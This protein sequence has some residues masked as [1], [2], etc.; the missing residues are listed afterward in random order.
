MQSNVQFNTKKTCPVPC[1][2]RW[3]GV[4]DCASWILKNRILINNLLKENLSHTVCYDIPNFVIDGI[5][6]VAWRVFAFLLPYKT[7]S[8][9]LEAESFPACYVYPLIIQATEMTQNIVTGFKLSGS[10][11]V[12]LKES[13]L[14]RF[15]ES[16]TGRILKLLFFSTPLGRQWFR[17]NEEIESLIDS[18]KM[19]LKTPDPKYKCHP[20][21]K[22]EKHMN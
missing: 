15:L 1:K 19:D 12:K 21:L 18:G 8:R 2:T 3:T 13:I 16:Q 5:N 17:S 10:L 22:S 4:F 7:L 11:A 9:K 20:G 6:V 14:H